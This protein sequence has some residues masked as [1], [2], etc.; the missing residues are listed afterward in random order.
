MA[1]LRRG[2]RENVHL[3]EVK[4]GAR[5]PILRRYLTVAAG[6]R[7]NLPVDRD[8]PLED[9]ERIAN[10]LPAFQIVPAPSKG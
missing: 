8:A 1:V 10:P 9:T 6:A 5:A 2:H 3:G 4:P 7:P